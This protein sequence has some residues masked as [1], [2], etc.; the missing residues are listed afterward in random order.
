MTQQNNNTESLKNKCLN[1]KDCYTI[2]L[3]LKDGV[4]AYKI[5]KELNYP[6]NTILNEIRHGTTTQI[7][8]GKP[9][10]IYLADIGSY[11]KKKQKEFLSL[12]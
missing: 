6:I 8:Q 3:R 7:K 10:E 11:L 9:A 4:S 2:E 5:V 1:D 12:F